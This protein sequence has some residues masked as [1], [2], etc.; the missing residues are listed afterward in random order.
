M[1]DM[2]HCRRYPGGLPVGVTWDT[3]CNR[4]VPGNSTRETRVALG[5]F[6][7]ISFAKL[8]VHSEASG[9]VLSAWVLRTRGSLELLPDVVSR[10]RHSG[11]RG[12]L[13]RYPGGGSRC[14]LREHVACSEG[15][16]KEVPK[17]FR[18]GLRNTRH[19]TKEKSKGSFGVTSETRGTLRRVPKEVSKG[20]LPG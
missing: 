8:A 13:R 10:L 7:G 19:T 2:W 3:W 1:V 17:G 16:P 14:E 11:T 5:G 18:L 4:S 15:V 6:R 12:S 20:W 9:R